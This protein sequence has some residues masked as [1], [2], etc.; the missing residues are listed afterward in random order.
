[1]FQ[2]EQPAQTPH[3]R[4]RGSPAKAALVFVKVVPGSRRD[5]VVGPYGERLKVKVAAPAEDGRANRAVCRLIAEKVG[6]AEREVTVI[7]GQ[8][9]PEK[10]LRIAGRTAAE[11]RAALLEE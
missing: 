3:S 7:V 9:H 6:V 10:T 5:E 1:M 4:S 8:T 2:D 11:L